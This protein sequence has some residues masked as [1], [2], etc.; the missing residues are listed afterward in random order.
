M[1]PSVVLAFDTA[2]PTATVALVRAGEVL[3]ER[4]SRASSVLADADALLHEAG[5]VVADLDAVVV[6]SGP[7][8]FTGLRI[9][10]AAALGL[11][12][13]R[14][15][16]VAAVSTLDSLGAGAPGSRPVIDARR[17]EIFTIVD[18]EPRALRPEELELTPGTTCVG[19]GAVRHRALLEAVGAV[20]PPDESDLHAPQARFH[21]LLARDFGPAEL[22]Q[23]L[24]VRAP[25]AV[26]RARVRT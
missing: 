26:R 20:I 22:V 19:D 14:G 5:L 4:R 2:T 12:L 15:V 3:G 25:D 24:Y 17:G 9:G 8:S 10:F 23:P 11:A 16:A 7:G 6:G 13:A 21:A 1:R 18:G